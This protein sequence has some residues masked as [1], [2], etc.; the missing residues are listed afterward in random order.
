MNHPRSPC[1]VDAAAV[2]SALCGG[3]W[4]F[5]MTTPEPGEG[6]LHFSPEG[7]AIQHSIHVQQPKCLVVHRLWFTVESATHLRFGVHT[8]DASWLRGYSL[9]DDDRMTLSAE[10]VCYELTRLS[11]GSIPEWLEKALATELP[12][13]PYA[14]A[15]RVP[16]NH[17]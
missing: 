8:N 4:R 12:A 7:R 3:V 6:W 1:P 10:D 14:D 17:C 5:S 2:V 11:S 16:T 9:I 13:R 15:S